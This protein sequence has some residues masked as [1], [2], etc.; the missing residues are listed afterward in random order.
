MAVE[1]R[2]RRNYR[3][4]VKKLGVSCDWDRERFTMD[5]G[6]SKAVEEV[7]IKLYNEGL[8]TKDPESSTG[9]RYV[10][11]PCLTPK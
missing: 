5:E 9:V 2:I 10:R 7:F 6:C 8:F 4:T 11:L 1:R 3:R